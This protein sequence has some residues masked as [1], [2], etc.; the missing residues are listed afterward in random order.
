VRW[1]KGEALLM[2]DAERRREAQEEQ[3][4]GRWRCQVGR[5]P[6]K[7]TSYCER[8]AEEDVDGLPLCD[9]HAHM[10]KL[11]GQISCWEEMLFHI[12]LW[13]EEATRRGRSDVLGLLGDERARALS[14]RSRAHE[15]L[16]AL[17][18]GQTPRESRGP[19]TT[20]GFLSLPPGGDR[21]PAL[22]LRGPRRR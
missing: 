9:V 5:V 13:S 4:E 18:R 20:T 12:D 1:A 21:P 3:Q 7:S 19:P 10:V 8:P 22:G 16:D 15:D 11:K 14:A 17:G 6:G 2:A